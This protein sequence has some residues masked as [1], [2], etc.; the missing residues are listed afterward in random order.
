[1][2]LDMNLILLW[3]CQG[4]VSNNCATYYATPVLASTSV[5]HGIV[6]FFENPLFH[7]LVIPLFYLFIDK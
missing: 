5:I 6:K 4:M 7:S 3:G 2:K 1:M